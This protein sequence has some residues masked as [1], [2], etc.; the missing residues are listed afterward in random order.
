MQN[1]SHIQLCIAKL[2]YHSSIIHKR[3]E[4][5]IL[6]ISLHYKYFVFSSYW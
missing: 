4:W 1:K 2:R 6:I 5:N 3:A